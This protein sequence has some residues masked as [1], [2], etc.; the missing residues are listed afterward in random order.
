MDYFLNQDTVINRSAGVV[1]DSAKTDTVEKPQPPTF[2]QIRYWRWQRE[3]Q[4]LVGGSRYMK[5]RNDVKVTSSVSE[6]VGIGLPNYY[7]NA[8]NTDWLTLII[9]AILILFASVKINFGN[10]LKHLFQSVFNVSTSARMF[11]EKNYNIFHAST[12]LEIFFYVVFSIFIFQLFQFYNINFK[13]NTGL[14]FLMTFI[15]TLA[16]FLFKKLIYWA[17]GL[18]FESDNETQEYLFNMDNFNKIAGLFLFPVVSLIAFNPFKTIGFTV[19][20]GVFVLVVFYLL[21]IQRGFNILLRK[22]FSL[23]YLFLYLCTLEFLPL[24]LIYK[25]VVM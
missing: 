18:L 5:P 7:K 19:V 22:H 21:L 16:Y 3:K 10:Y 1:T 2:A 12:R 4:L 17:L 25:V 20:L 24:L 15:F 23:L 14:L 11:N 9:F 6:K 13:W 8:I